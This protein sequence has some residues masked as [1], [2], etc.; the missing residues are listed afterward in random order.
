MRDIRS[1]INV[2]AA[3]LGGCVSVAVRN[4]NNAFDYSYN[5]TE[6][7]WSASVIKVPVLV[8][9]CK[10]LADGTATRDMEFVLE[11]EGRAPGSGLLRY[12]TPGTKLSYEDLMLLMITV[13]DNHATNMLI[14]YLTPEA[15][16]N[17]MRSFGYTGTEVQRKIF[18][19]EGMNRGLYNWITAGEIADLCK[20][21]YCK[22]AAGGEA[23]ELA[24]EIMSRTCSKTLLRLYLPDDVCVAN[25]PGGIEHVMHDSGMLWTDNFSYSICVTTVGWQSHTEA[26]LTIA[27]ISRLI[28][29]EVIAR[30]RR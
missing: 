27:K 26:T 25:K 7:V 2:L 14:D 4:I 11:A 22:Q 10:R 12:M 23:D 16:T 13:S 8:E 29:D 5:D 3:R 28:Y 17:T 6:R 30:C 15:I 19:Y 18:D 9:A 21:I 1:E 20:R 24:L